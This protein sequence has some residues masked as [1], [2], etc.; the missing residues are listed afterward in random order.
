MSQVACW[1]LTGCLLLAQHPRQPRAHANPSRLLP[2]NSRRPRRPSSSLPTI[3]VTP[4]LKGQILLIWNINIICIYLNFHY[5]LCYTYL[6]LN[7]VST[8][9]FPCKSTQ[10][11][12][13]TRK[14][15]CGDYKQKTLSKIHIVQLLVEGD[16]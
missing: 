2:R 3:T 12:K 16:N 8:K 15:T 14:P 5:F 13:R 7:Y 6:Q 10:E 9:F 11:K 1:A 4:V